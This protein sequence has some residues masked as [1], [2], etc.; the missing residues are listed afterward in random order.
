M[1][2]TVLGI[3]ELPDIPSASGIEPMGTSIFVMGDDSPFLF[4]LNDK[5]E[6][7]EKIPI[8]NVSA[9]IDGKIPKAQKPDLEAMVAFGEEL[10][11]FGSGSKSPERDV[12]VR[13]NTVSKI[14]RTYSLGEFYDSLC[15][16][17]KITRNEL[18]IEAAVVSEETLLLFNRKKNVVFKLNLLGL[19]AHAEGKSKVPS[20]ERFCV[21]LPS[22]NGIGA[23][24]SGAALT[25]DGRQII[26]STSVENT[27]NRI[28]DG[29]ILG[30][31]VGFLPIENLK[32]AVVP[33]C[34][35]LKDKNGTILKIKVES[36]A[37][38]KTD[39]PRKVRL[40]LVTD[41]DRSASEILEAV[42]EW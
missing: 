30:S 38:R 3:R 6:V 20:C 19:L 35:P 32:E 42:F 21:T 27:P 13:L 28:D 1:K 22:L 24:F 25:P 40:L 5:F 7:I 29:E 14:S 16:T 37:V 12:L 33:D 23:G 34:L 15:S 8:G 2:L 11:L 31:F 41:N 10:L 36:V 26:F 4:R 18:N 17:E 39:G 9:A